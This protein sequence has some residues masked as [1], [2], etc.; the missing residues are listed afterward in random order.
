MAHQGCMGLKSTAG[1]PWTAPGEKPLRTTLKQQNQ[2]LYHIA[3]IRSINAV[4]EKDYTNSILRAQLY[5]NAKVNW[6]AEDIN[7]LSE[8]LIKCCSLFS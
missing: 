3:E 4:K 8:G 7:N 2:T 6:E 1:P 5:H